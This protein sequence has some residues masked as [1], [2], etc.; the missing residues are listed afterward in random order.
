VRWPHML[1]AAFLTT[2]MCVA[3]TGAWYVLRGVHRAEARVMLHWGL[4][5]AAVL[6]PVQLL[7]G[8][9]TGLYLYKHQPA[10]LAAIEARWH[11]EQP[12][13]EVWLA[14]PNEKEERNL[15]A[16]QTRGIGS[17]IDTGDWNAPMPGLTDF[18]VED[19]PPVVIPFFTFRIMVG[20]GIAMLAISWFGSFL[21][22]RGRLET[23]RWFLQGTFLAFPSGFIATLAG[24][25]TA[26]I[27][28][29]PWVVYGLL[30][31]SEAVTPSLKTGDVLF[32]LAAYVAVYSVVLSFGVYYIYKLLH[33]GPTTPAEP[34]PGT[35]A[36]RP[37]AYGGSA[38][39]AT[40]ASTPA[41]G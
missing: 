39:D 16:I 23:T 25:Y 5:L 30:R 3:A 20:M 12:G 24:W 14:W 41:K 19:R 10:K 17:L 21:R 31:T 27:G 26:E 35:T 34:I 2:A 22:L 38:D 13:N 18:P 40:G 1:L 33:E 6:I 37:L 8:H 4:G 11:F 7:F 15:F 29:Q 28:R 36:K 32:S 9:L